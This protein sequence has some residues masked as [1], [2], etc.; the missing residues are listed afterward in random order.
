MC[1]FDIQ[2]FKISRR[3]RSHSILQEESVGGRSKVGPKALQDFERF[4]TLQELR[5]VK[6]S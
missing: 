4:P 5:K 6:E 2:H 3:K 1:I